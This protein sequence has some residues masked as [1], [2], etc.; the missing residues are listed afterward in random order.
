MK[1]AAIDIGTNAARLLI[2]EL[3]EINDVT[4]LIKVSYTR[5]PLRL[6]EDVFDLGRISKTKSEDFV[7]TMQAFQ[8]IADIFKVNDIRA[9]ATS[10]MRDAENGDKIVRKI[11]DE[12]GIEIEIISGDEEARIIF[13]N[14]SRMNIAKDSPYVVIDVGGGSTEISVFEN[15][16]RLASKSFDVGTIRIL[17]DKV[18]SLIW[19]E[20]HLW[21][22]SH[23]NLTEDH[24]I[25]GTGGNINKAH[26]MLNAGLDSSLSLKALTKLRSDLASVDFEERIEMYQLKPD[27]ADVIIPALDIYIYILKEI[28]AKDIFVPKV[29]L[30]DG[31]IFEMHKKAN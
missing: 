2:G 4:H 23:V 28:K 18:S 21:I 20:I 29:G 8:L 19:S 15:G 7:K 27:R 6:G 25:F 17:K 10:A 12:T 31:M 22:E 14:F 16:E 26:K 5:I 11:I 3:V 13:S 1:Y 24:L 30:T 9:V